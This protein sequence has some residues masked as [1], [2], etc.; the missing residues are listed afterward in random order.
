MGWLMWCPG[1]GD[2]LVPK[3]VDNPLTEPIMAKVSDAYTDGLVQEK[4][5]TPVR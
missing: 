3:T 5:V 1:S 4:D 2:G